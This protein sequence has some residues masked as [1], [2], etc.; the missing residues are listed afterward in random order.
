MTTTQIAVLISLW[1]I[2]PISPI[3]P[4]PW[5]KRDTSVA[6]ERAIKASLRNRPDLGWALA[7][8]MAASNRPCTLL[9]RPEY[10]W[11]RAAIHLLT[12]GAKA[13]K[14]LKDIDVVIKAREIH[15]SDSLRPVMNAALMTCEANTCNI[16]E[17]FKLTPEV[18]D[19]YITL[20]F[21]VPDRIND[22][23]LIS[24]IIGLRQPAHLYTDKSIIPTDEEILLTAGYE[25]TIATVMRLAGLLGGEEETHEDLIKRVKNSALKAADKWSASPK[26]LKHTPPAIVSLGFALANKT[27]LEQLLGTD[28]GMGEFHTMA[29]SVLD[30]QRVAV[31]ASIEK[32]RNL[33]QASS[34]E[35]LPHQQEIPSQDS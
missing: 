30:R 31:Q 26:S 9:N 7:G 23:S 10:R 20:F 29:R 19:A 4:D 15:E 14:R 28:E 17:A 6:Q 35:L 27:E 2:D 3:L 12:F 22:I 21:N 25:G 34:N 33:S 11:I 24:S 13:S 5:V 1:G 18:V 8:R 32:K 16:A